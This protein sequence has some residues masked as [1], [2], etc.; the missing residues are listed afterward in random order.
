MTIE[1]TIALIASVVLNSNSAGSLQLP[2]AGPG[3]RE[4]APTFEITNLQLTDSGDIAMMHLNLVGSGS[5]QS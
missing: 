2:S 3:P 4:G 5:K 1:F